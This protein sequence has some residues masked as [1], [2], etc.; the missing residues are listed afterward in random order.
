LIKS[1]FLAL[2]QTWFSKH[3]KL[4]VTRLPTL[5][6]LSGFKFVCNSEKNLMCHWYDQSTLTV[7]STPLVQNYFCCSKTFGSLSLTA[8]SNM[9]FCHHNDPESLLDVHKRLR[10]GVNSVTQWAQGDLLPIASL[11]RRSEIQGGQ[12]NSTLASCKSIMHLKASARNNAV[13]WNNC[14]QAN[15]ESSN[16][17]S[18][19]AKQLIWVRER[20]QHRQSSVLCKTSTN[21]QG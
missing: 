4:E 18:L 20:G 9:T 15:N 17:T 21:S 7:D 3:T 10:F 6:N 16:W 19:L 2:T 13:E 5:H 1:T 12:N 14:F 11:K 8:T